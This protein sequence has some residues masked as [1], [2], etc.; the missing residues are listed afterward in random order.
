[1]TLRAILFDKDGTLLD[2]QATYAPSTADVIHSLAADDSGL[3]EQMA[4]A[5]GFDLGNLAF[6]PDSIVIAETGREI[7]RS[8]LP[9]LD[10][11]EL[12][13]LAEAVDRGYE[14]FSSRHVTPFAG[15]HETLEMLSQRDLMLGIATNDTEVNAYLHR[16]LMGLERLLPFVAGYDSGHGAKPGPGMVLAFA[17]HCDAE[18]QEIAMIGDSVHDMHCARNA[19]AIAIAVATGMAS[20]EVLS[21]H[22]D[23]VIS[24]L[25]E[26]PDLLDTIAG[27]QSA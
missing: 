7:A 2:F 19:G 3:A 10:G 24:G 20:A 8:W 17:S 9:L 4:R 23:H 5:I 14:T 12:D 25:A 27:R 16:N 13:R 11:W 1:M 18:P 22:S 21:P 26:L 6:A 15:V